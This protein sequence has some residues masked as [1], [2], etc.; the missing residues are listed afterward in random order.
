MLQNNFFLF[1][2]ELFHLLSKAF[3]FFAYENIHITESATKLCRFEKTESNITVTDWEF[4]SYFSHDIIQ[5][6]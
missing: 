5:Q 1:I 6:S 4:F 3:Y 2:W